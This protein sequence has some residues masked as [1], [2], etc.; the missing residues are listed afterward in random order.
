[1]MENLF[2]I[3][4]SVMGIITIV[5][6]ANLLTAPKL[7]K[8]KITD[9]NE[10]VSV[11]IPARN[12]EQNIKNIINDVSSQSYRNV[13]V[14]ILDDDSEDNTAGIV[15]SIAR[16]R[17]KVK[18]IK[19]KPLP[20]GWTGKNWACH[21]LS[22]KAKGEILLFIDADVRLSSWA[23]ESA[24]AHIGIY[25]LSMLSVFPAQIMISLSEKIVVAVM[26]WLLLTFL[27]LKLVYLSSRLSFV[28]AN[29]QF[30]AFTREAYKKIGG[31]RY[32]SNIIVE[33]MELARNIKKKKLR[34]MTFVGYEEVICRMY[35]NFP[36]AFN[37]FSKNFFPGFNTGCFKFSSMLLVLNILYSLPFFL[38]LFHKE[39]AVIIILIFSQR[40]FTSLVN[41]Q[42][43]WI[44]IILHP[45]QM[46][47]MTLIG[48]NSM[49]KSKTGKLKW[50][51][52]SL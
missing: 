32:V 20:E 33:D 22:Q 47:M 7:V 9:H 37:G 17:S 5:T 15:S 3:Y 13:E 18:M 42:N 6:L 39:Y 50:K 8:K 19:G 10:T 16:N 28:A 45:L 27:P 31:H 30:I 38:V 26:D 24:V 14:I 52:R 40:L 29:G 11:C 35:K 2:C 43:F 49:Y 41:K 51:D 23:I 4:C 44:N 46:F 25:S 21:Q 12:E 36:D 1:M 34:M 48:I